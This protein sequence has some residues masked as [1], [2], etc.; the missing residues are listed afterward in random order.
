VI[1]LAAINA[2][3][4]RTTALVSAIVAAIVVAALLTV[5]VAGLAHGDPGSRPVVWPSGGAETVAGV[6]PATG[7]IFFAFAGYARIATLGEEVRDPVRTLPRA[8]LLSVALVLVLAA[9][10]LG[11][12]L[13]LLGTAGLARS[14]SPLADSAGPGWELVVRAAAVL[15]CVGSMTGV[16][17]GLSRTAMAMGRD[18][19]LPGQLGRIAQRS[20]T[21]VVAD[22]VVAVLALVAIAVLDARVLVGLSACA[23]LGYYALAHVAALRAGAALGLPRAVPVIGVLGCLAVALATPWPALLGVAAAAGAALGVRALARSRRRA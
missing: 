14:A 10:T 17:A 7:L 9:A 18:G 2:T 5:L 15:A 21:P 12:L 22:A 3:G 23:V 8:V 4:V 20:A 1:A 16:L 11:V 13:A 19:E 6:L